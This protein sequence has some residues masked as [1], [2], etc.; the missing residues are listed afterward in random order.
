ME[1]EFQKEATK[2]SPISSIRLKHERNEGAVTGSFL[3]PSPDEVDCESSI[4][5]EL[6]Q[7]LGHNVSDAAGFGTIPATDINK[8]TLRA[9]LEGVSAQT[10]LALFDHSNATLGGQY[11]GP[12]YDVRD[13][14]ESS[15]LERAMEDT[16]YPSFDTM[17][18]H[19]LQPEHQK[20]VG[21]ELPP[22]DTISMGTSGGAS[23]KTEEHVAPFSAGHDESNHDGF[24]FED[25]FLPA[26]NR[27]A[28]LYQSPYNNMSVEDDNRLHND[29]QAPSPV[30]NANGRPSYGVLRLPGYPAVARPNTYSALHPTMSPEERQISNRILASW[31]TSTPIPRSGAPIPIPNAGA[32]IPNPNAR[33][34]IAI[35]NSGAPT[36]TPNPGAPATR[37]NNPPS[38]YDDAPAFSTRSRSRSRAS[39]AASAAPAAGAGTPEAPS[40]DESAAS[41]DMKTSKAKAPRRKNKSEAKAPRRKSTPKAKSRNATPAAGKSGGRRRARSVEAAQEGQPSPKRGRPR[42]KDDGGGAGLA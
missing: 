29:L 34:P 1:D 11:D 16:L 2:G 39:S 21:N 24:D 40:R 31:G 33:G 22:T 4:S 32:P 7:L 25:G 5:S 19:N 41:P 23:L 35:P 3:A 12:P 30:I 10:S 13:L 20:V 14:A 8:R 6:L 18:G 42:K 38:P 37:P 36:P 15:T 17:H 28:T 9:R 27:S 26:T